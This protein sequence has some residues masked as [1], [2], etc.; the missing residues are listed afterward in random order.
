MR[1]SSSS[2]SAALELRVCF[3]LEEVAVSLGSRLE[4]EQVCVLLVQSLFDVFGAA[5]AC[6]FCRF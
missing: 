6:G 5:A 1:A 3:L 2:S 4:R